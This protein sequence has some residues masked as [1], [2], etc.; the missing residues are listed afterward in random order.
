MWAVSPSHTFAQRLKARLL[1]GAFGLLIIIVIWLITVVRLEALRAESLELSERL[2]KVNQLTEEA[3][4]K[5]D[6]L[7][8]DEYIEVWARTHGMTK[9]GEKKYK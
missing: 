2:A 1:I 5:A 9:I 6:Y 8:S 4:R 3:R 7:E